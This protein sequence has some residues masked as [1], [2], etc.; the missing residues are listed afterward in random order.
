MKLRASE[1]YTPQLRRGLRLQQLRRQGALEI[2][3][4]RA[5]HQDMAVALAPFDQEVAAG[6]RHPHLAPG[7]PAPR[8]RDRRGAGGRAA[9]AR[10]PGATLPGPHASDARGSVT[11]DQRDVGALGKDG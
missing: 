3:R 9:G 1:L 10:E 11:C 6:Q 2:E 7:E 4:V 8:G 5:G